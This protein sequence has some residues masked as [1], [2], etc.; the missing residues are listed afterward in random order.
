VTRLAIWDFDGTL[1]SRSRETGWS[2]LLVEVLDEQDPGHGLDAEAFRPFLR[3][4]FPWH[5]PDVAHPEL[6]SP[7][8]WWEHVEPLLAA[9][10]EGVGYSAERAYRFAESAHRRYVD[11]GLGWAVFED[12]KPVLAK[13]AEKGWTHRIL[14]NHV[15]E[16]KALVAGLG[17]GDLVASVVSSA[18][19][20]YEKPH[21]QAFAAALDGDDPERT[22]MIGD[23]FAADVAGA[24]A[25]GLSAVLVR[26]EHPD[27][28]RFSPDLWGVE[29]FLETA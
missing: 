15:P 21:P 12:V 13:L 10:F 8:A 17:L 22:W 24:E 5:T 14:S 27:A 3:S 20:G 29:R 11:P 16:L 4:G 25:V 18:D 28:V 1:A 7:Q 23:N 26:R 19:T 9:A 2:L 6:C